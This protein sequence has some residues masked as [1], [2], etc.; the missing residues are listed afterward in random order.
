MSTGEEVV[1][2]P[3]GFWMSTPAGIQAPA[4][5]NLFLNLRPSTRCQVWPAQSTQS[6]ISYLRHPSLAAQVHLIVR[7]DWLLFLH[8]GLPLYCQ[9]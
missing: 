6:A 1:S 8:L 5:Q 3:I 7:P 4:Y 2:P 9:I